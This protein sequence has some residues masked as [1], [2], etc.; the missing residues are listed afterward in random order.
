MTV[1]ED[2]IVWFGSGFGQT[3][4]YY[5]PK[6]GTYW[7]SAAITR[8]AGQVYGVVPHNG[9]VFFTAYGGGDH[10]LYDPAQPWNQYENVNPKTLQSVAPQKMGRPVAGSILGP[11]GNYW[12]GWCGTYGIYGG[13]LSRVDAKTLEVTGWFGVVPEQ[14]I[15]HLAAGKKYLYATS[16][17]MNSGMPYRFDDEFSLLQLDTECNVL[18]KKQFKLGQ[19]PESLA[20]VGNRLYMSMRDRLD[21]MAKILVFDT[22][23]M[24][25]L[26]E[27]AMNPLGGPGKYE[28]EQKSIRHLLPYG[29]DKLVVFIDEE[30][31]L[32]DAET[33]EILQTAK[34]PAITETCTISKDRTIYCSFDEK[35]YRLLFD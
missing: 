6:N 27:K 23:T 30:A 8:S 2:G 19:F 25:Q 35:L 28:M 14:S 1:A 26:T 33:L 5:D 10:I 29:E 18:W 20:V 15:R 11:D 21:G 13:G 16:H 17:W 24:E 22:E 34:L 31:H 9:T 12:T 4:G 32:V 7:N 3:V